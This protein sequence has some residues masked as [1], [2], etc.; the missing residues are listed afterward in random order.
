MA[1][2]PKPPEPQSPFAKVRSAQGRGSIAVYIALLVVFSGPFSD[3]LSRTPHTGTKVADA[4]Q[5]VMPT[6]LPPSGPIVDPATKT[7]QQHQD[8]RTKIRLVMPTPVVSDQL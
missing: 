7:D 6:V 5:M 3:A 1:I 2:E 4:A 8:I